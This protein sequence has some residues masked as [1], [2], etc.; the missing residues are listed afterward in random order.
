MRIAIVNQPWN[1]IVPGSITGSIAV[2]SD[3]VGGW[4]GGRH[5]VFSLGAGKGMDASP[6]GSALEYRL[7]S[8]RLDRVLFWLIERTRLRNIVPGPL[9]ASPVYYGVYGLKAALA[10]RRLQCDIVHIHN[11]TQFVQPIR[12]LNPA[13]RIVLHM[14]CEWLTELPKPLIGKRLALVDFIIGCSDFVLKGIRDRFPE[15]AG[16]TGVVYNGA[17]PATAFVS[18]KSKGF[19]LLYIGRVSPEKGL[20]ILIEAFRKV[21]RFRSDAKLVIAGPEAM[22]SADIAS[23]WLE[24]AQTESIRPFFGGEYL[25]YLRNQSQ[26]LSVEFTGKVL[27]NQLA[28][29]Y[30]TSDLLVFP[31]VWNEPFGMP[32]VEA[33]A[34]GLPVVATQSGGIPE[35]IVHGKTGTLVPR[36]DATAL[37]EALLH[38]ADRKGLRKAMGAQGRLR[39]AEH[40]TW[41]RVA[42]Q[43]EG[44][45]EKVLMPHK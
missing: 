33:M 29:L 22:P 23:T 38:L 17:A 34:N 20:H 6:A 32:I 43:V 1:A 24:D 39:F 7:L 18:P 19:T 14:H 37:A 27:H 5:S 15:I 10:L 40:F 12:L 25:N 41:D 4:L 16:Q 8:T 42:Q 13:A 2:W 45:Y 26:G 30:Q 28:A 44:I 31:S 3:R 35:I 21:S 9:Y 36:G 11:L